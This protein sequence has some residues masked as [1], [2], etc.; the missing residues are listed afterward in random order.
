MARVMVVRI[1]AVAN[2]EGNA[3]Y[4]ND[5]ATMRSISSLVAY[6]F[7]RRPLMTRLH[8]TAAREAIWIAALIRMCMRQASYRSVTDVC[9]ALER[10]ETCKRIAHIYF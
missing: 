3:E 2:Q 5:I 7:G 10:C 6:F 4:W 9:V 1:R 8:A